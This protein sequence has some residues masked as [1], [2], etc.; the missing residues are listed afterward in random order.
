[1]DLDVTRQDSVDKAAEKVKAAF[2]RLDVLVN[3]AG[4]ALGVPSAVHTYDDDAWLRTFDINFH[5]TYRVSKAMLPLM[6]GS[7]ACIIN[8][9]SKAG[10]SPLPFN[11]AYGC[12]KAA[13]ITLSKV[14]AKELASFGIRVN[15]I[16]PGLIMTGLQRWRLDLEAQ[17]FETT[18]EEREKEKSKEIPLGYFAQPAVVAD[19]AAFLASREASYITGQ[20]INVD[21]GQVMEL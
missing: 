20:A 1:M 6:F 19:L 12:A 18:P 13:V 15:A 2:P 17:W 4:A 10:K 14:M 21:G 8:M 5:G 16:C 7:G 11:G 9:A 3:N